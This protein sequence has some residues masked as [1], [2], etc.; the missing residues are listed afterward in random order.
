MT[1]STKI[2]FITGLLGCLLGFGSTVLSAQEFSYRQTTL[3]AAAP[4]GHFVPNQVQRSFGPVLIPQEMPYPGHALE[5]GLEQRQARPK[6]KVK[7]AAKMNSS[8]NGPTILDTLSGNTYSGSVPNDDSFAINRQGQIVS[9]RNSTI[10]AYDANKDSVL[11][12][13]TLFQFYRPRTFIP[14][15]K[16]DPRVIYDPEADRFIVLYLSGTTWEVSQIVIGFSKSSNPLDGFNMY[17]V[18]GN[19]LN[20]STWSDYPHISIT[21]DDLFITMNTFYNGSANNT[22]YAQSTIRQIDK[23]AGYDSLPLT[24]HYYDNLTYGGR[25]MFNFTGLTGGDELLGSPAYF[26]N[27]R[28]FT[29]HG[30]RNDTLYDSVYVARIEGT[31]L[32]N[33]QLKLQTY[34]TENQYAL[35]PNARQ[36]NGH[37]FRTNDS[38]VQGGFVQNG[39]LQFVGN[40]M[41]ADS[42]A[43]IYHGIIDLLD[44]VRNQVYFKI[45]SYDTIDVGYPQISYTGKS[46]SENEA[47]ITMNHS[48]D[49]LYAG[50][51]A[52]F[53]DNDS[54]YSPL[55]ILIRGESIIDIIS[56]NDQGRF[57][58][59]WG[60]YTGAQLA[61][62]DTGVIWASGYRASDR[63]IPTTTMVKLRS[64]NYNKA[65][66][67]GLNPAQAD[68]RTISLAPNPAPQWFELKIERKAG[69]LLQ[70]R[71]ISSDGKRQV[72]HFSLEEFA[73]EGINT[74]R[75]NTAPLPSG[76]YF[77]I[78]E[79]KNG[80]FIQQA[81]VLKP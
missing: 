41:T 20:D 15:S 71:L 19:P 8:L 50:F 1:R 6:V 58:E 61:Y 11:F 2:K 29:S 26:I 44:T 5:E 68:Q 23:Q 66:I 76:L 21:K 79:D 40:T 67:I 73:Y 65:P 24:Q 72:Q 75:F 30:A 70:F 51:S 52:V 32:G 27:L 57:Y 22:G 47:I 43:G 35:P 37:T 48:S 69:E 31:A 10:G 36:A 38:R 16:Y 33:P 53:F 45:L 60:D 78:I 28:S 25:K 62:Q 7:V 64:P 54:S 3:E 9:V 81:K 42:S 46:Y 34:H 18:D 13:N 55:N 12:Q 56:N 39:K 59:R 63:G 74:F 80:G 4:V 17:L 77:L 49:S 14:G